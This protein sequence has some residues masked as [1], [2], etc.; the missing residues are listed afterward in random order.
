MEDF[1]NITFGLYVQN[2]VLLEM[3]EN[4]GIS[5]AVDDIIF[6]IIRKEAENT[7]AHT[8]YGFSELLFQISQDGAVESIERILFRIL[9][10]EVD[11]G[12]IEALK[13]RNLGKCRRRKLEQVYYRLRAPKSR[14]TEPVCGR[15]GNIRLLGND[16][17]FK[18]MHSTYC[19]EKLMCILTGEISKQVVAQSH[20]LFDSYHIRHRIMCKY[21]CR[22][23]HGY[24]AG[25]D[26]VASRYRDYNTIVSYKI[27][28]AHT[29]ILNLDAI[30]CIIRMGLGYILSN[31]NAEILSPVIIADCIPE[32]RIWVM[33]KQ[34]DSADIVDAVIRCINGCIGI[35]SIC[36]MNLIVDMVYNEYI[37][38]IK[39]QV[40]LNR[41]AGWS[42]LHNIFEEIPMSRE[43]I[44]RHVTMERIATQY[45]MF[46]KC[47]TPQVYMFR[48]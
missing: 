40:E 29:D 32:F 21:P 36:D 33:C 26:Y 20:E 22:Y 17:I 43:A 42:Y 45:E 30:A 16:D 11:S 25:R 14:L 41:F 46:F 35:A 12:D 8:Y 23:A 5:Y 15:R 4:I 7:T 28:I 18:W 34:R 27:D 39:N 47:G 9:N 10:N 38:I 24:N 19:N 3:G 13:K 2:G 1:K 37:D 44:C 31:R 48:S 6:N